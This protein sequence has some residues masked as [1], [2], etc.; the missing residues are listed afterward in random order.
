MDNEPLAV[1]FAL[2]AA[3][4]WGASFVFARLGLQRLRSTTGTLVSLAAGAVVTLSIAFAIHSEEILA[5]SGVTFLWLVRLGVLNFPLGRLLNYVG[6]DLVGVSRAS[7]IIGS[8]PLFSMTLALTI[9]D[10][11]INLPILLGTTAIIGGLILIL[12]QR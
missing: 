8:A 2:A 11:S 1:V 5:L 9:L 7:P 10:E 3:V 6:V 4:G 12:S